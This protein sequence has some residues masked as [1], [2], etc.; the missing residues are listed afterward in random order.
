M[1]TKPQIRVLFFDVFGT[2]VMQRKPVADELW[3]ATQEALESTTAALSE[4][5]RAKAS[6]LVK[7]TN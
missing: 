7:E 2:C 4:E 1:T 5:V 6:K 3:R